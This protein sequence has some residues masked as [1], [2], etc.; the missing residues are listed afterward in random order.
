M[1]V[2]G[3]D[4][5]QRLLRGAQGRPA[6]LAA[7]DF[8]A[9]T[10]LRHSR[11]EVGRL[12][13]TFD[14]MADALEERE[15]ERKNNS[16]KLQALSHKLVEIQETERRHIAR[17]LHDEIGQS[18]VLAE[19]N[20]Q[21]AVKN[22]RQPTLARQLQISVQ[23][24]ERVLEQVHD[25]SL[26]LRPSLLDD[27]GLEAALQRFTQRQAS[28]AGVQ[29]SLRVER[30]ENRLEPLIENECFRITHLPQIAGFAD[31]HYFVEKHSDRGRTVASIEELAPDAR[32]REIGRMLSGE[33]ITQEALTNII[34]HA[35][36]RSVTIELTQEDGQL[37]LTVHDDGVGFH[38]GRIREAAQRGAS[39][40]LLGM[41]ERAALAGGGLELESSSGGGT[42]IHAWFPLKWRSEF[43]SK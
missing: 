14:Q 38:V 27:L 39:L 25:L 26:N 23:A 31:H 28:L 4:D 9:R 42:R 5:A 35:Q 8:T 13:C 22:A 33:R 36:A 1:G 41:E 12:T 6:R 3:R 20:L 24:V 29:M 15:L 7:G 18:L 10:G 30:M 34:R 19:M 17:E 32:T 37:H 2:P 43:L 11:N 16:R 40:G 21:A